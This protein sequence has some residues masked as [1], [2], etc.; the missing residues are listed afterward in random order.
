MSKNLIMLSGFVMV[1]VGETM[2]V[3]GTTQDIFC[4]S[5]RTIATVN[6]YSGDCGKSVCDV[7]Y[8]E[9]TYLFRSSPFG[10]YNGIATYDK[11]VPPTRFACEDP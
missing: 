5:N 10:T 4:R 8:E 11:D 2:R 9:N 1:I 3:E 7:P 6:C